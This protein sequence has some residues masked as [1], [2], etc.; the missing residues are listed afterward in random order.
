MGQLDDV[1]KAVWFI[2]R[3]RLLNSGCVQPV[4]PDDKNAPI[5]A[6]P[7]SRQMILVERDFPSC[8]FRLNG[9]PARC[10]SAGA[11]GADHT[12]SGSQVEPTSAPFLGMGQTIARAGTGPHVEFGVD[13]TSCNA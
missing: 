13:R 10:R 11:L 12:G 4:A 6:S 1:G 7:I 9:Y 3:R 5:V 8:S 2:T